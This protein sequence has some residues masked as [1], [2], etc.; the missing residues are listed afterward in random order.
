MARCLFSYSE[1]GGSGPPLHLSLLQGELSNYP[2]QLYTCSQTA[3]IE[4]DVVILYSIFRARNEIFSLLRTD[5]SREGKFVALQNKR[6]K[7][8]RI[9]PICFQ[10]STFSLK[11]SASLLLVIFCVPKLSGTLFLCAS[12]CKKQPCYS[13]HAMQHRH[14]ISP[15]TPGRG[16]TLLF[17]LCTNE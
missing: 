8:G 17:C 5:D 3:P 15:S 4:D 14:I 11:F 16:T 13:P 9:L 7:S 1:S 6:A 10:A 12:A 2:V